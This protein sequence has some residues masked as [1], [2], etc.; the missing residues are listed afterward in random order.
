MSY[1]PASD[2][3]FVLNPVTQGTP[4]HLLNVLHEYFSSSSSSVRKYFS[5]SRL[6]AAIHSKSLHNRLPAASHAALVSF[7]LMLTH[8]ALPAALPATPPP[9]SCASNLSMQ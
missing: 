6:Q 7:Q 5:P 8:G 1:T 4:E 9:A 2:L 3:H